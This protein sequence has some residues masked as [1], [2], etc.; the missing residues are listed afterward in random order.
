MRYT[1]EERIFG[2]SCDPR[3]AP[4]I[5]STELNARGG[6]RNWPSPLVRETSKSG[7]LYEENNGRKNRIGVP[8]RFKR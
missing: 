3:L 5:N 4:K 8:D 7:C 1:T 6:V 2:G